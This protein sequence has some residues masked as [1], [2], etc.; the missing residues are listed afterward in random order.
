M[1]LWGVSRWGS[2]EKQNSTQVSE[3]E[4]ISM[5]CIIFSKHHIPLIEAILKDLNISDSE[6]LGKAVT[7][8]GHP[9]VYRGK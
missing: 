5:S 8:L 3:T 6:V 4:S 9:M 1:L 7:D 2:G